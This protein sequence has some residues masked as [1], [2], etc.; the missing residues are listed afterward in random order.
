M[1]HAITPPAASEIAPEP[2]ASDLQSA[3]HAFFPA[4][5]GVE[6]VPGHPDLLR[7]TTPAGDWRVRRWPV[8]ALESDLLF[9][10]AVMSR[11]RA[12]GLSVVPEIAMLPNATEMP[13]LRLDSRLYDAQRWLPGRPPS[14]VEAIWPEPGDRIDLPV[15]LGTDTFEQVISTVAHLHDAAASLTQRGGVPSAP[16]DLFPGAVRQ[17]HSRHLAAL[18]FQA[19][20]QPAIQRWL[21]TGER[22][23]ATAEPLVVAVAGEGK[24]PTTVLHRGLWPVHV[25]TKDG[26][27]TG[28]LGW[29]RAAVGS[30]LLDLAQAVLRLRGWSDDAVEAT[31][32]AYGEIRPLAPQERRLLPAIAA[33]EAVATTGR[34]LE[35]AYAA[36]GRG[37]PPTAIRSGIDM[38]LRSLT[39][40]ER[41]VGEPVVRKRVWVPRQ[42]GT[43]H[44]RPKGGASRERR[45]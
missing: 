37:T 4:L 25:L 30:P 39:A 1:R 8:S 15:A 12:S 13:V 35:Q 27:L 14:R 5:S 3:A 44:K 16:L 41:D 10:H 7:V 11:A 17:A 20:R 9:S 6:P 43:A 24:L 42:T 19:R 23:M 32:S 31:L 45:R 18:R 36:P 28:L 21:A 38:M 2:A 33:L 29:E 22:L 40:L 26:A 34:L